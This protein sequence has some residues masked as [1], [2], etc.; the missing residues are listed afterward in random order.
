MNAI[1]L[2]LNGEDRRIDGVAPTTMLL[3]WLR[4]E[5]L[6]GTKEGCGEGDCGACTVAVRRH[7][8]PTAALNACIMP[9]ALAHGAHVTTVEAVE[10]PIKHALV[11][12]HGSQCG[13]CTPGFVMTVAAL[14]ADTP[15]DRCSLENALAGNLCRC[16]GYGPILA[17][18]A[19]AIPAAP[20]PSDAP[21]EVVS[22]DMS[23]DGVRFR[24]PTTEDEFAQALAQSPDARI[25]AGAT[26]VGLWMTKHLYEAAEF[27]SIASVACLSSIKDDGETLTIG[28]AVT[29]AD[30]MA[31]I[32]GK[33]PSVSELMRR[34]AGPQ[35]RAAGTVCGNIANGSPIGDL[36]P[37]LIAAGATVEI[38]SKT[39][40]RVIPLADFFIAY[41]R[42][43]R[44]P[45]EY[46]RAL[47]VSWSGLS[48]VS[49][50]KV[51]KRFDS[52]ISA[53]MAAF[54]VTLDGDRVSAARI[55]FGGMA[56]TPK[57][58]PHAEAALIGQP[59][60]PD[61]VLGA[62]AALAD[63]FA[64]ISDLRA[65]AEYRLKVAG[66]LFIRDAI[67][68]GDKTVRTRLAGRAAA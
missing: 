57:R 11:E 46:V 36:P 24:C 9:I 61:G 30:F 58:A 38:A 68:R 33:A 18:T 44:V 17:A 31:A 1:Q 64:P 34:F 14:P 23:A 4:S 67:E 63:D 60:T 26:D 21:P 35:V 40:R 32:A 62:I 48:S 12:H 39:G 54:S 41:G 27:I 53:V 2:R 52:D 56:A 28:A 65:S 19:D 7:G 43:D 10:H 50:H 66:K 13:F 15:T 49:C 42:Q 29:H 6:T 59:Y 55:A 5:G 20:S 37:A 3:D 51:S 25:I 45:G 8:K 47:R 16:T 22:L